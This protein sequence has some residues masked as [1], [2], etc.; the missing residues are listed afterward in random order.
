VAFLLPAAVARELRRES[1]PVHSIGRILLAQLCVGGAIALPLW[2]WRGEPAALSWLLGSVICVVPNAFVGALMLVRRTD[3]RAAVRALYWGEAGKL[4]LTV[5][6]F[7]AAF[8]HV[9]PLHAGLLFA[10]L[11]AT[12]SVS[13]WALVWDR[14]RTSS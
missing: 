10:G 7:V 14:G 2:A 3:P 13:L 5:A 4:V 9:R 1:D 12:Q 8:R 11:I 6:L